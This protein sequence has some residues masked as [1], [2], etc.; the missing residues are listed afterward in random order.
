MGTWSSFTCEPR[1]HGPPAVRFER[2]LRAFLE[3]GISAH[4]FLC[5]R[6]EDSIRTASSRVRASDAP[7][8]PAAYAGKPVFNAEYDEGYVDDPSDLCNRAE[9]E[10]IRVLV[11][12]LDLDDTFRIT[13]D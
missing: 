7:S 4:G 8:V 11:L 9:S 2:E 6:C 5:V 3:C 10:Q 13:C 1:H 12:P